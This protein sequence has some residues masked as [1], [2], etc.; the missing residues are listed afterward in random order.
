MAALGAMSPRASEARGFFYSTSRG[1]SRDMA[2]KYKLNGDR[3]FFNK[4]FGV[5]NA[6]RGL[7]AFP[8]RDTVVYDAL[9]DVQAVLAG[10][11]VDRQGF[12]SVKRLSNEKMV[13]FS[14]HHILPSDHR[15]S[16]VW[17]AN[18]DPYVKLLR[19]YAGEGYLI[20]ENGDVEDL[21]ILEP[22]ATVK[23]YDSIYAQSPYKKKNDPVVLLE[24]FRAN[25]MELREKLHQTRAV[26]RREQF[27]KIF[28][29]KRNQPYYS[30]LKEL[31]DAKQ[32]VRVA[33]NHDYQLQE[34]KVVPEHLVPA[35]MLII[36]HETPTVV[37]HGHQFDEAT[38]PMVAPFYGEIISECLGVFYQ[39]PD[40]YWSPREA[41]KMVK[42]GFP[43]RLSTHREHGNMVSN[44][45]GAM[46]TEDVRAQEEWAEAWESL[47]GHPIAWEYGADNWEIS[48][49]YGF[50][51]PGNVIE[52]AM[53][54]KQFFKYRHLDEWELVQA[55]QLWLVKM[56]LA[57]GHSHEVR[58]WEFREGDAS[59]VNS[60]AAGR[61]A[62]LIWA[63]EIDECGV[64]IVGW[65]A[66][67]KI[68]RYEF[69]RR[70][71]QMSSYFASRKTGVTL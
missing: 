64:K 9:R 49:K 69:D 28:H 33:G 59:Y 34:F 65:H 12:R 35:D 30:F 5:Q 40:R 11:H 18:R 22:S 71:S 7:K 46:L 55:M 37:M 20:V 57:L 44:F 38:N 32:L 24:W 45:L 41:E 48:V 10:K 68:E 58:H 36:D 15:Q 31:A 54:G 43:N 56:R 25:P 1:I 53:S 27:L 29:E 26:Y 62:R 19:H 50:A 23:A 51:R 6:F 13:I 42:F 14:D 61:F 52:N 63:L 2:A 3:K 8:P 17:R 67:D 21:V 16:A 66:K 60:G 39:G 70:E 47:F 4:L